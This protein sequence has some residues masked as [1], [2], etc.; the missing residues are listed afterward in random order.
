MA[1]VVP[2]ESIQENDPEET[3]DDDEDEEE[4]V[5]E[6][7]EAGGDEGDE[8]EEDDEEEEEEEE[9]QTARQA[10]KPST[11]NRIGQT[12][13]MMGECGIFEFGGVRLDHVHQCQG[14]QRVKGTNSAP[15]WGDSI[16]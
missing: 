1:R 10:L 5:E 15:I 11:V 9:E 6:V 8:D 16:R 14:L 12:W 2:L 13:A 7:E 4:E 3:S